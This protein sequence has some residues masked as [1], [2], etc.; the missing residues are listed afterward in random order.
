MT[1]CCDEVQN[2]SQN[3]LAKLIYGFN[4]SKYLSDPLRGNG[5]TVTDSQWAILDNTATTPLAIDDE[6]WNQLESW[7]K[8][9]EGTVGNGYTLR[10]IVSFS[11]GTVDVRK[12]NLQ[13]TD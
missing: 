1:C 8:L 6:G 4:W 12:F 5:G 13:I 10:N 11:N 3:V 7:V 2:Y 9:K